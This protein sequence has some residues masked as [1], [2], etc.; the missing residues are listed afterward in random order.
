MNNDEYDDT[1]AAAADNDG[2]NDDDDNKMHYND[3]IMGVMVSQITNLTIVYS[4]VY[5]GT[6]QRKHQSSASL[7]FVCG[8]FTGDRWI[9][10][11]NGQ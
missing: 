5:S 1:A 8:E 6:D 7:V 9:P 11:T 2:D 3:G 4:I 10:R